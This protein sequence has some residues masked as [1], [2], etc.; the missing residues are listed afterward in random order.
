M[1]KRHIY[2][3]LS[4]NHNVLGGID[5]NKIVAL[6]TMQQRIE[7]IIDS[8]QKNE[9]LELLHQSKLL[10]DVHWHRFLE[11]IRTHRQ[12]PLYTQI[13]KWHPHMVQFVRKRNNT[14]NALVL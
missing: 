5:P 13:S 10:G 4:D 11:P 1:L 8:P 12:T 7:K 3:N 2:D 14:P 9:I 6:L